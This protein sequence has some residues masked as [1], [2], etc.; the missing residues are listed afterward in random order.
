[1]AGLLDTFNIQNNKYSYEDIVNAVVLA[2]NCNVTPAWNLLILSKVLEVPV[3][4]R[5]SPKR[6]NV[7]VIECRIKNY[8]IFIMIYAR[9]GEESQQQKQNQQKKMRDHQQKSR[10]KRRVV[11]VLA[12]CSSFSTNC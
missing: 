3:C 6:Q 9:T 5:W 2:A 1:M 8:V 7:M 4:P 12:V 10:T 11:A